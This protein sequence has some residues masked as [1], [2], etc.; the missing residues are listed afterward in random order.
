MRVI[1]GFVDREAARRS[2]LEPLVNGQDDELARAAEPALR[3]DAG[4]VR[5][6]TGMSDS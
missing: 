1:G 2:M 3:E 5:L 6:G 4:E